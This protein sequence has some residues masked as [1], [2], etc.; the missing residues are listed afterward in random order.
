MINVNHIRLGL[1]VMEKNE[2]TQNFKIINS[3]WEIMQIAS[4]IRQLASK[5]QNNEKKLDWSLGFKTQN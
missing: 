2:I 4:K 1:L 5:C 3:L